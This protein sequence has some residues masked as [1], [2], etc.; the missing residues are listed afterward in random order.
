[1]GRG[2]QHSHRGV[3]F[4]EKIRHLVWLWNPKSSEQSTGNMT[5]TAVGQGRVLESAGKW[6]PSNNHEYTIH[7]HIDIVFKTSFQRVS[8]RTKNTKAPCI[9]C[10][11]GNLT[12]TTVPNFG[13]LTYFCSKLH[14]NQLD[15]II[16]WNEHDYHFQWRTKLRHKYQ[17]GCAERIQSGFDSC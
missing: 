16:Y 15:E 17:E 11:L 5:A 6:R 3:R 12:Y 9:K 2:I 4:Q 1:M 7:L 14:L 10:V 13:S 8:R